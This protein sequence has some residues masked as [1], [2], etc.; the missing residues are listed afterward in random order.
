MTTWNYRLFRH[1]DGESFI[2]V[3]HEAY[4]DEDGTLKGWTAPV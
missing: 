3:I 1:R 2:Y 4:Y